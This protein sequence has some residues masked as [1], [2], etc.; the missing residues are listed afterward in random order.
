MDLIYDFKQLESTS[1]N[2]GNHG[3]RIYLRYAFGDQIDIVAVHFW[4]SLNTGSV[5]FGA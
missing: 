3:E 1:M 5:L 4:G 2:L